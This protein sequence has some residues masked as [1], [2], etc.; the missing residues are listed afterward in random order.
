MAMFSSEVLVLLDARLRSIYK[1]DIPF[2]GRTNVLFGDFLQLEVTF[3]TSLCKMLDQDTKSSSQVKARALFQIFQASFLTHQHRAAN[4]P[5]QQ[6]ILEACRALPSE[7]PSGSRW[8]AAEAKNFRPF[9]DVVIDTITTEL[10]AET[11]AADETWLDDMTIMVTSNFDKAVLTS[12]MARL[13][14]RRQGR[15]LFRWRRALKVGVS[16]E[17]QTLIYDEDLSPELFGYFVAGAPAQ[18]LDNNSGN[19]SWSVANSTPCILHS[20]A[21]QDPHKQD[22]V[23]SVIAAARVAKED[24]VELPFPPN[25]INI[26]L[27]DSNGDA[28]VGHSWPAENNLESNYIVRPDG[29]RCKKSVIIP[30]GVMKNPSRKPT[31][32]LGAGV[33]T[34]AVEVNLFCMLL[35]SHTS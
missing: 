27:L 13:F 2:G 26:Q 15:Q 35:I 24:I 5:A 25:F 28:L 6:A 21:W 12:F 14:A 23:D 3:G 30:V 18:M 16:C 7:Y 8:S 4:C 11:L 33:L 9:N 1:T 19:V 31:V 17:L 20:L 29:T 32:Q 10:D 34:K 22:Q